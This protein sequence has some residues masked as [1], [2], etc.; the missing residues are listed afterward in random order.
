MPSSFEDL[1]EKLALVKGAVSVVQL[2]VMDG[3]FVS[4]RNW[5]LNE[6]GVGHFSK[7]LREEEGLPYWEDFD[8]EIDFM[9]SNPSK[10]IDDWVVAGAKRLIIHIESVKDFAALITDIR[11]R[12]PKGNGNGDSLTPEFGVALNITTSND[13]IYP[14]LSE[15]DFVQFMGIEKIG[16]QGQPFDERVVTKITELRAQSADYTISVDGGVSLETVPRLVAAGANRLCV[17]SALF[18]SENIIETVKRLQS[19]I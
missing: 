18:G 16:F 4:E 10:G 15:M 17:G 6:G 9:V 8:F 11:G 3:K 12:F 7:I 13:A 5:P 19:L 1:R 14:F 2:D